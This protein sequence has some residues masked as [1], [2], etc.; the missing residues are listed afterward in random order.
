M[1]EYQQD[2]FLIAT[3]VSVVGMLIALYAPDITEVLSVSERVIGLVG[4]AINAVGTWFVF[5]DA[6]D[7]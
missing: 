4:L 6:S 3:A 1:A 2:R 5:A 7:R